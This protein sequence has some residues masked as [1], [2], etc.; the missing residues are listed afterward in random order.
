MLL[1]ICLD[2][3]LLYTLRG[4]TCFL[5]SDLVSVPDRFSYFFFA[6]PRV[7]RASMNWC[8][9]NPFSPR[10]G[11]TIKQQRKSYADG[12]DLLFAK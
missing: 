5:R 1:K 9:P 6:W 2:S 3:S 12:D 10:H 11:E 8:S 7:T 4:T